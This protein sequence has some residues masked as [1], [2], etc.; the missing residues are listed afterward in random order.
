MGARHRYTDITQAHNSARPFAQT[1]LRLANIKP[2][3]MTP[4]RERVVVVVAVAVATIM[5]SGKFNECH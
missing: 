1:Y 5:K 2:G 3:V 4:Y